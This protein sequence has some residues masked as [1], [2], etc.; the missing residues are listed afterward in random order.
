MHP[1]LRLDIRVKHVWLTE[2]FHLLHDFGNERGYWA[3]ISRLS[4]AIWTE[5][6]RHNI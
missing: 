6:T 1:E 3:A 2:L 4:L 5:H